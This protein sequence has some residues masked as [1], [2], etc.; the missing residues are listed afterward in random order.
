MASP[1]QKVKETLEETVDVVVQKVKPVVEPAVKKVQPGAGPSGHTVTFNPTVIPS[2][3][4]VKKELERIHQARTGDPNT[5]LAKTD[6]DADVIED[7]VNKGVQYTD[8]VA[9]IFKSMAAFFDRDNMALP[10]C[11]LYFKVRAQV[12]INDLWLMMEFLN[13]RGQRP[14]VPAV[15]PPPKDFSMGKGVSD[16]LYC[17]EKELALAK[18]QY[19]KMSELYTAARDKGDASAVSFATCAAKSASHK[20]CQASHYVAHLKVVHKDHNAINCFDDRLPFEIEELAQA[21]GVEA[22]IPSRRCMGTME[23]AL[24][25][26]TK[27]FDKPKADEVLWRRVFNK[28]V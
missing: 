7:L 9:G 21:A 25:L 12:E 16:V 6:V 20:V 10:G 27:V 14:Q 26:Q 19:V 22:T 17:F 24:C 2:Y 11:S 15:A 4:E 13:R 5:P 18:V 23:R 8:N 3:D 1:I 28:V